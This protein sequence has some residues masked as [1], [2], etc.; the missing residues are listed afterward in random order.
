[1]ARKAI[2]VAPVMSSQARPAESSF[3]GRED[4]FSGLP[5]ESV[6]AGQAVEL[7]VFPYWKSVM[8]I[9]E[10]HSS[11]SESIA[12]GVSG[13]RT[14]RVR[15][16]WVE[17]PS[18]WAMRPSW[19]KSTFAPHRMTRTF[20]PASLSF[21]ARAAASPMA[22]DGSEMQRRLSHNLRIA[23]VTCALLTVV[24]RSRVSLQIWKGSSPTCLTAVPSQKRSTAASATGFPASSAAF[25]DA[26][27]SPSTPTISISGQ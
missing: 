4:S 15:L 8:S 12:P 1:M 6:N 18:D 3:S 27:P 25:M 5:A 9:S 11:R 17:E 20:F 23:A 13:M 24:V 21:S 16:C 19:R 22:P 10:K 7:S 2:S 14:R 26:W